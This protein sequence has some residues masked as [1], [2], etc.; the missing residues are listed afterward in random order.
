LET[1]DPLNSKKL[2]IGV[3]PIGELPQ[4]ALESIAAHI[5]THLD[6]KADILPPLKNPAYA[7]DERRDQYNAA[8]ILKSLDA[9]SFG[10]HVKVIGILNVDLFVPIF[11]HVLGEAREGG[12]Y[13]L[14]SLYRLRKDQDGSTA[15]IDRLLE[16]LAKVAIHEIGHT[17]NLGHCMNEKC[18]MHFSGGLKGLDAIEL[19][20][21]SYCAAFMMEAKRHYKTPTPG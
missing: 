1:P 10:D 19:K 6:L 15:D 14:A 17:F 5:R 20:F 7:Y 12:T 11:T 3:L 21:C 4:A 8:V 18:L 16:R 13:A 9:M 2:S